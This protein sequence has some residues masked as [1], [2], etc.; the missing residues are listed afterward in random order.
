MIPD[1][2]STI[3]VPPM[4]AHGAVSCLCKRINQIEQLMISLNY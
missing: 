1:L 3:D 4:P 2:Q